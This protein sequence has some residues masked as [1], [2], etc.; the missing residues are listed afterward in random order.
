MSPKCKDDNPAHDFSPNGYPKNSFVTRKTI[1][2]R[3]KFELDGQNGSIIAVIGPS[4]SGK[5]LLVWNFMRHKRTQ[6]KI[7][8]EG[9]LGTDIIGALAEKLGLKAQTITD[10]TTGGG[11]LGPFSGSSQRTIQSEQKPGLNAVKE[12]LAQ[13]RKITVVIDDFH[14][15]SADDQNDLLYLAKTLVSDAGDSDRGVFKFIFIYIPT[16][17]I[18]N[19]EALSSLGP[20]ITQITVGLWSEDELLEIA[21]VVFDKREV[22]VAGLRTFAKQAMG[23]PSIMQAC[24]REYCLQNYVPGYAMVIANGAVR[25][26]LDSYR[27]DLWNLQGDIIHR[28]L[29]AQTA[30][31]DPARYRLPDGNFYSINQ[32]I[33]YGLSNY[34]IKTADKTTAD[35]TAIEIPI[36]DFVKSLQERRIINQ[37]TQEQIGDAVIRDA[38]EYMS[39]VIDDAYETRLA[40]YKNVRD[41]VFEYRDDTIWF[42]LPSF[43]F[44]LKYLYGR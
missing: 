37:A 43:L 3:L 25:K 41:P 16:K 42:Y 44:A 38:I 11:N 1:T 29:T 32:A 22:A 4:Q 21:R 30:R 36:A 34:P 26:V 8:L 12:A 40:K 6:E 17:R 13:R 19:S 35:K 15:L 9:G 39:L 28:E 23:L 2:D 31:L 5:T 10:Q 14:K 24:C 7:W 18:R 20:R 27:S 33:L